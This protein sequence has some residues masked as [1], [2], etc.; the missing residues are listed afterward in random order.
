MRFIKQLILITGLSLFG[1]GCL[2][3]RLVEVNVSRIEVVGSQTNQLTLAL[4]ELIFRDVANQLKF[5]VK[6]P[7]Q[8]PR[9]PNELEFSA[10]SRDERP[11]NNT[12]LHLWA[13]KNY[14]NF[15]SSIYGTKEDFVAAQKAAIFFEQALDKQGIQ[16]KVFTRQVMFWGS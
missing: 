2:M 3:D 15:G 12:I 8:D 5:A 10:R 1:S 11:A 4:A 16:Y 7:I 9:T 14:I 6:G 13:N